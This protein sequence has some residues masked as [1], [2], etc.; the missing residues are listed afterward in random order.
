MKEVNNNIIIYE[1]YNV[2]LKY[3]GGKLDSDIFK[4]INDDLGFFRTNYRSTGDSIITFQNVDYIE[5]KKKC[6]ETLY[7]CSPA[8]FLNKGIFYWKGKEIYF[9]K[10]DYIL[11]CINIF[12]EDMLI[13]T[14][15]KDL[16][17]IR[18][19]LFYLI[20]TILIKKNIAFLHASAIAKQ[21]RATLLPAWGHT[22][23]T[24]L[25]FHFVDKGYKLYGDDL[26]CV[27]TDQRVLSF[28]ISTIIFDYDMKNCPFFADKSIR[29]NQINSK[30][31]YLTPISNLLHAR[32]IGSEADISKIVFLR[33]WTGNRIKFE[34]CTSTIESLLSV[35]HN[36]LAYL[37]SF[38]NLFSY[39]ARSNG[40]HIINLYLEIKKIFIKAFRDIPC[41]TLY[42]P[43]Y[44]KLDFKEIVSVVEE[45]ESKKG[46]S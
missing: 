26:V 2:L 21:G 31:R 7:S 41:Y 25:A 27:T 34:S 13:Q 15:I 10:G 29:I 23:K 8:T 14:N 43:G 5:I 11:K 44:T 18:S 22:L 12:S 37:F 40:E 1:I 6:A 24:S 28:P 42:I 16:F 46:I 17:F 4:Q 19:F 35:L 32:Q 20:Q 33:R 45:L 39:I 36:E 3:I 30:N 9:Q 38:H